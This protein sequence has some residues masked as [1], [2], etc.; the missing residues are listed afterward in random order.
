[1][2]AGQRGLKRGLAARQR[3]VILMLDETIIPETPPLYSCYGRLGEQVCIPITG[4]R[5]KRI[6]HGVINVWNGEVLLLITEEWVQETHQAFLT[7]I[8]SHWRGWNIVLFEDRG[9]PHTAEDSL[10]MARTMHIEL[11]FLPTATPELNAMDHLWRHVKGRGLANRATRTIDKSADTASRYLLDMSR[12]ERLRK[13]GVLSG[14]FWLTKGLVCRR[15][16]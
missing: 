5:A 12:R 15:T 4:N 11:R 7:M 2:A 13:A 1:V 10:V 9:A 6:L 14:N 8:R 16:F 3:T